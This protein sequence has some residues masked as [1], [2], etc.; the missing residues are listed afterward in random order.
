MQCALLD[1]VGGG[2]AEVPAAPTGLR[3]LAAFC[4]AL[5]TT[6]GALAIADS[7]IRAEPPPTDPARSLPGIGHA[8]SSAPFPECGNSATDG[9]GHFWQAEVGRSSRA[10]KPSREQNEFSIPA[11]TAIQVAHKVVQAGNKGK[12][13]RPANEIRI[14]IQ[15]ILHKRTFQSWRE[16]TTDSS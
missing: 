9:L 13:I 1:P 10:P 4:L 12:K 3:L 8:R 5:R 11:H 14:A 2:V 15:G 6:A 7:R 16:G